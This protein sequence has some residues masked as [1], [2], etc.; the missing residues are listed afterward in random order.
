MNRWALA[1]VVSCGFAAVGCEG[2]YEVRGF[3]YGV[4]VEP[5]FLVEAEDAEPA[6]SDATPLEYATVALQVYRITGELADD[7]PPEEY[8]TDAHGEFRFEL[9]ESLL[10]VPGRLVIG[11]KTKYQLTCQRL[12]YEG[13]QADV[14]LPAGRKHHLRVFLTKVPP[15]QP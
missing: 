7:F 9:P 6:P 10:D 11:A 15:V 12:G 13:F 4:E 14:Q 2:Q 1:L 5:A 3:V 8:Y